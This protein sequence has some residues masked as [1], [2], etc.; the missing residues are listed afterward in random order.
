MLYASMANEAQIK[1]V[2]RVNIQSDWNMS[3]V[4]CMVA[5]M[6]GQGYTTSSYPRV[7]HLP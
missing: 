3:V 1:S 6:S 2:V 4:V 5:C 7:D